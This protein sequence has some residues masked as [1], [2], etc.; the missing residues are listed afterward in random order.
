[1]LATLLALSVLGQTSAVVSYPDRTAINMQRPCIPIAQEVVDCSAV[2]SAASADLTT[3][4]D[5]LRHYVS[6]TDDSYV[7]WGKTSPTAVSTDIRLPKHV[8]FPFGTANGLIKYFACLN[9]SSDAD[10]RI[11][12]CK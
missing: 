8:W 12:T 1:M 3:N 2:A 6:C 9:V 4:G 11:L 5:G 10:C 7:R